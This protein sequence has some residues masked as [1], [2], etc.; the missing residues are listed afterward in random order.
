MSPDLEPV[1]RK[2][3]ESNGSKGWVEGPCLWEQGQRIPVGTINGKPR[4]PAN[5]VP[6]QVPAT[7]P[8][9][10]EAERNGIQPALTTEPTEALH[11]E[12]QPST[13]SPIPSQSP[14]MTN[15][16]T[17][18]STGISVPP[19][20]TTAPA[21]NGTEKALHSEA[22]IV[23]NGKVLHAGN[24]KPPMERFVTAFEDLHTTRVQVD[25][26]A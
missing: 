2:L 22:P 13:I 8:I 9:P 17:T 18:A 5:T 10:T 11:A 6:V 3:V 20:P 12:P 14:S 15:S 4:R 7:N 24:A 19:D 26:V 25:G 16:G 1:A 21:M 23:A